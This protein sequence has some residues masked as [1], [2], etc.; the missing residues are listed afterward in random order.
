MRHL[1]RD[2]AF[3]PAA[4]IAGSGCDWRAPIDGVDH[5][6][7]RQPAGIAVALGFIGDSP[8]GFIGVPGLDRQDEHLF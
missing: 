2:A 8:V 6:V 7:Q 5:V 3:I 4:L 1:E